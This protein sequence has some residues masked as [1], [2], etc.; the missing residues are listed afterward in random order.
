MAAERSCH[1][2]RIDGFPIQNVELTQS[3]SIQTAYTPI[4]MPI[5]HSEDLAIRRSNVDGNFYSHEFDREETV[6]VMD[7]E[8][9]QTSSFEEQWKT[10][11]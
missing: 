3:N 5:Q 9:S 11:H 6:E 8:R 1:A 2:S 7:E 4:P 10:S